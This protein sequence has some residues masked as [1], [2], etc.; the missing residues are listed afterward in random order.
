M[1]GPLPPAAE[2]VRPIQQLARKVADPISKFFALEAASGVLLLVAVV[3]ALVWANVA[4]HGYH[5]VFEAPVGIQ[6]GGWQVERTLHFW[7]NEG[8]MTIFFFLV[9]LEIRRELHA[10]ELATMRQAAMPLV[11]AL[12]GVM[13][14]IAIFALLNHGRAGA[15]GWAIPMATDI[16][17]ALGVLS[18]LGS[19]VAPSLRILL[20]GLAVIDDIAAILVIAIWF[21]GT[22][23]AHGFVVAGVGVLVTF[24]LRSSGV[25]QAAVYIAP[26]ALVW[27]GLYEAGVHPTL[28]GVLLGLLTPV[29]TDGS[30]PTERLIQKLHPWVAFFVMPGFALAN[31][32]V[33]LGGASLAGDKLWLFLG[34]ALGLVVGKPFGIAGATWVTARLGVTSRLPGIAVVG[35]VGGIGFTMSLFIAELALGTGPLLDT[36]K[37]AVLVGSACSMLLGLGYGRLALKR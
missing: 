14:P 17:F 2:T 15:A 36:A 34:I 18:L 20:L 6:V 35:L 25:R 32:G 19:R 9:G 28:A 27:F 29:G 21:G 8:L 7:V 4:G 12:G 1:N 31:A 24:L 16:A 5:E 26:G 22:I 30:S 37:L 11:A 13:L 3:A 23:T 10:G 33:P